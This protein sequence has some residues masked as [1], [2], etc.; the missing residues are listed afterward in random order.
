MTRGGAWQG[1]WKLR[2]YE[3]VRERGYMSITALAHAL[4]SHFMGDRWVLTTNCSARS[5]PTRKP[6]RRTGQ[7]PVSA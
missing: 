1:N 3:R 5:C 2:L 7:E 6:E 4:R